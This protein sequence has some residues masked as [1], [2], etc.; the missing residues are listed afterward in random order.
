MKDL[1]LFVL[2][3]LI[4]YGI[5]RIILGIFIKKTEGLLE[6]F[7]I[8]CGLGLAI[9]AYSIYAIGS[10]GF[11][12]VSHIS[13]VIAC[14]FVIAIFPAVFFVKSIKWKKS[15]KEILS[16]DA[17]ERF[18]VAVIVII[19]AVCFIGAKAPETG[20]DALAYH[21]YHPKIFIQDH[22]IG[23]IPLTRESMWPYLTEMLFT[24][25]LLFKSVG[26]AKLVNFFFGILSMLAVYSFGRRFFS[27]RE[28]L[29]CAA[30]FYSA[31]G[32][33]MQ[34]VYSYADLS[35][36]F[37]S[38]LALY[39]FIWWSI[40]R[41]DIKLIALSGVFTGLALSVKIL[42]GITLISICMIFMALSLIMKE[43]RILTVKRLSI[44]LAVAALVS[45]IWYIRSY[46]V[47]GNPVYPFLSDFFRNGWPSDLGKNMGYRKD[48]I[49]FI[50]LPWDLVMHLDSFGA[51]QIGIVS[52]AFLPALFFLS[53]KRKEICSLALFVILYAAIWFYV[54][55]N[56]R[57][58]FANIAALYLLIGAGFI[59]FMRRYNF[60]LLRIILLLCLMFNTALAVYYNRDALKL[61]LGVMDKES[62]LFKNERTYPV[63]KFINNNLPHASIILSIGEPRV[64]YFD[65][66]VIQY[67]ILRQSG[68]IEVNSYI[69]KLRKENPSLYILYRSD[70]DYSEILPIIETKK[71]IYEIK[72]DIGEGQYAYYRLFIL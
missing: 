39:L 4:S 50:R 32:I 62:Y 60:P 65:R 5:G 20:N 68:N 55:P 15:T 11:L 64:F 13:I 46:I 23:H 3:V 37:Y 58:A 57:F 66:S 29:L 6:E 41:E 40:K 22:K 43:K 71:P 16:L 61:D 59:G 7:T 30:L 24:L 34:S 35:L 21:L 26:L 19:S 36:C 31:P 18:L 47:T 63:A 44:F 67:D 72:R 53:F 14:F 8:S 27:K 45:C 33:F 2:I 70:V 38:F 12:Y 56:I 54:D 17:F 51:E 52:L 10:A 9:L 42:G 49:G 28:A 1:F 69:D 48:F 25:G